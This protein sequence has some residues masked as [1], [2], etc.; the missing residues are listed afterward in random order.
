MF[1]NLHA[2]DSVFQG[3]SPASAQRQRG[4]A[5][6]LHWLRRVP[7][8]RPS[9]G[10]RARRI[11]GTLFSLTFPGRGPGQ[12]GVVQWRSHPLW[13]V[14]SGRTESV[15]R[16]PQHDPEARSVAEGLGLYIPRSGNVVGRMCGQH[17]VQD[18]T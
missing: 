8:L 5:V 11:G 1:K 13:G 18:R 6:C 16:R 10:A 17:A 14:G 9:R 15:I 2:E 12:R 4:T 7:G 3:S